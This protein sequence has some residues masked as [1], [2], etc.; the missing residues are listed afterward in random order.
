MSLFSSCKRGKLDRV[1]TA[2]SRGEMESL[3]CGEKLQCVNAALQT[4]RNGALMETL[5]EHLDLDRLGP[6]WVGPGL[7]FLQSDPDAF[8]SFHSN[9][10][11][12]APASRRN[13]STSSKLFKPGEL[14]PQE[15]PA[16]SG[17]E[18][19]DDMCITNTRN[20]VQHHLGMKEA[21]KRFD[22]KK[23]MVETEMANKKESSKDVGP[24]GKDKTAAPSKEG[25]KR[26]KGS[27]DKK[28]ETDKATDNV[29]NEK[30]RVKAELRS[31][32][33][34]L[35][36]EEEKEKQALASEVE[37]KNT[38]V[39]VLESD[40]KAVLEEKGNLQMEMKDV[41]AAIKSLM[42]RK[43]CIAEKQDEMEKRANSIEELK[44][45]ADLLVKQQTDKLKKVQEDLN[46][47]RKELD[48]VE[49][50]RTMSGDLEK[51]LARQIEELRGELECPVC[52]EVVTKA[53]IYKCDDDHLICR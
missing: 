16:R 46:K 53:P 49:G 28:R 45:S 8:L 44:S 52:M 25:N 3:S 12:R 5:M 21:V 39:V 22:L 51:F 35:E 26:K 20:L 24:R 19:L 33:S 34:H 29:K 30:V 7:S 36:L 27:E 43:K 18:L 1:K 2:L 32:I 11:R 48:L 10:W 6:G 47:V 50:R 4:K 17:G 31:Q 13:V 37:K 38:S 14:I 23:N 41:D 9:C 40:L 42:D 15:M